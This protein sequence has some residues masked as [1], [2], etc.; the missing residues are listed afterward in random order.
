MP[1]SSINFGM[2]T[3]IEGLTVT[4]QYLKAHIAGLGRGETSVFP[5][6]IFQ[7]KKGINFNKEDPNYDLFRLAMECSA[8]RQFPT[9]AFVDSSFNLPYY[10]KDHI[11]GIVGYMGLA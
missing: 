4:E 9:Y 5:I 2:D 6:A 1:V 11:R 3:S 8:K 7:L 10:E